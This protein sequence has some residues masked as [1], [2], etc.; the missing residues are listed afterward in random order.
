[1]LPDGNRYQAGQT[2]FLTDEQYGQ[3]DSAF[4]TAAFTGY[5]AV[6]PGT[7]TSSDDDTAPDA[8]TAVV[9]TGGACVLGGVIGTGWNN[10]TAATVP[11]YVRLLQAEC[12]TGHDA[13]AGSGL[14]SGGIRDTTYT[15]PWVADPYD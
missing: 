15:S 2:A 11:E 3:I 8:A 13:L 9:S 5:T 1:V 6:P 12:Q 14:M 7:G 4:A 10:V